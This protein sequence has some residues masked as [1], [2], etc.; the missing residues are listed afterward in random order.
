MLYGGVLA[1][2]SY[3]FE[4]TSQLPNRL[5]LSSIPFKKVVYLTPLSP[6]TFAVKYF[7]ASLGDAVE[8]KRLLKLLDVF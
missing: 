5:N 4:K 3:L 2:M 6:K 8:E 7:S 1:C